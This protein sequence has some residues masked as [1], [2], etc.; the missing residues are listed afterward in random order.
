ME[1]EV[2]RRQRLKF[3][4]LL[5][6]VNF[7]IANLLAN[8]NQNSQ[9]ATINSQLSRIKGNPLRQERSRV[10]LNII[11]LWLLRCV[12]FEIALVQAHYQAGQ[13]TWQ[14]HWVPLSSTRIIT[15]R[16]Y[17]TQLAPSHDDRSESIL[18]NLEASEASIGKEIIKATNEHSATPRVI[19]INDAIEAEQVAVPSGNSERAMRADLVTKMVNKAAK[20]KHKTKKK[21]HHL[22]HKTVHKVGHAFHK[23]VHSVHG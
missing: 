6:C 11:F 10:C 13:V 14:P 16:F 23:T 7:E 12:C 5:P 3:T 21:L 2:S 4:H 18:G 8:S 22:F 1:D 19:N 15:R 20:T 9:F 17:A